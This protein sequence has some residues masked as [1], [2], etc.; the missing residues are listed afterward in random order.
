MCPFVFCLVICSFSPPMVSMYILYVYIYMY[1]Y[2]HMHMHIQFSPDVVLANWALVHR[3]WH[4]SLDEID[5]FLKDVANSLDQ[6]EASK[7]NGAHP[8][9]AIQ[10]PNIED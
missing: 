1:M 9:Q 5:A 3:L 10:V 4:A 8:R 2:V 6:L 7:A